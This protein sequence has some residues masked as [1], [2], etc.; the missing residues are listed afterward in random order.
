MANVKEFGAIGRMSRLI[1]R[2]WANYPEMTGFTLI[3]GSLPVLSSP[4]LLL[5][6]CRRLFSLTLLDLSLKNGPNCHSIRT[7]I[8][9]ILLNIQVHLHLP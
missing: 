6:L 7:V 4:L 9:F 8:A 5:C 2:K 1:N 3:S